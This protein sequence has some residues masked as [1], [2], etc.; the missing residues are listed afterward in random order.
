M[1]AFG[2]KVDPASQALGI[3]ATS[4][5]DI[6]RYLEPSFFK[7]DIFVCKDFNDKTCYDEAKGIR[8]YDKNVLL[9]YSDS[10]MIIQVFNENSRMLLWKD[11]DP[12]KLLKR[13]KTLVYHFKANKECFFA[14]GTKIDVTIHDRGSRFADQF[15][16]LSRDLHEYSASKI[17]KS[18]CSHFFQSW[19][20]D[21]RIFFRGGGSGSNIPEKFMQLSLHEFLSSVSRG[22]SISPLREYNTMGNE[23]K[24]KPVDIMI[25]WREANRIALIEVKFIGIVKKD[26]DGSIY[27]NGDSRVNEGMR[28]L[29]DY[30]DRAATD[31]P[32]TLIKSYLV[33]IDGRR[34][35]VTVATRTINVADGMHYE[36]KELVIDEDKQFYK[37]MCNFEEPIRMFAEPICR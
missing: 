8:L 22:I 3:I 21:D 27:E 20:E 17:R 33:V 30:F 35:N 28:Q 7:G 36:N 31:N 37:T 1:R 13:K 5:K 14:N 4:L 6:Y 9:N 18:S 16:N 32:R 26:S 24:P 23:A 2:G 11:Q 29:K 19:A 10:L 12:D 15:I 34:N 25:Q